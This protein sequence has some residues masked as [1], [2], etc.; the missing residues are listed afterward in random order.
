MRDTEGALRGW[1]GLL[2]RRQRGQALVEFTLVL[3]L[4]LTLLLG[5][6]S[7]G[8]LLLANYAVSQAARAG[9]HQAAIEGGASGPA[10]LAVAQVLGAGVGTDVSRSEV[11]VACDRSGSTCR[12][13]DPVTVQV[14]YRDSFWAP[15]P[16]LFTTFT[17]RAEATRASERD[18]Q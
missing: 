2:A 1:R 10:T 7:V 17:V 14:V 13:Y 5:L 15:L 4:F 11:T 3:G 16:P 8:Q 9:A 6:V 18:Q 12:R